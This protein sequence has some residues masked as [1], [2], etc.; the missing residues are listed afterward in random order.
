M[1]EQAELKRL[2][3]GGLAYKVALRMAEQ[4][5]D[6]VASE[7]ER[8]RSARGIDA[9]RQQQAAARGQPGLR[10]YQEQVTKFELQEQHLV[11]SLAEAKDNLRLLRTQ[12]AKDAFG[13]RDAEVVREQDL[14]RTAICE[15]EA[16][17]V[18][19]AQAL[20]SNW[21]P[22]EAVTR[23]FLQRFGDLLSVSWADGQVSPAV[24]NRSNERLSSIFTG[25]RAA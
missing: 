1:T 10:D 23:G 11:R 7:I 15:A 19:A 2:V 3:N 8:L 6:K 20:T 21:N 13:Q 25:S 24:R 16:L 9:D 22:P 12:H 18:R 4:A 17:M 5:R 14:R